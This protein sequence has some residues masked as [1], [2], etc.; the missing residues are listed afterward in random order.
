MR[1]FESDPFKWPLKIFFPTSAWHSSHFT[2]SSLF[3]AQV[4]YFFGLET[5]AHVFKAHGGFSLFTCSLVSTVACKS[6]DILQIH[7]V[8]LSISVLI[9]V[10]RTNLTLIE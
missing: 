5:S 7:S 3:V 2:F 9:A 8:V 1:H 4:L 6:S 10:E